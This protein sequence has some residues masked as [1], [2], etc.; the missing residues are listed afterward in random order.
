MIL[1][2]IKNKSENILKNVICRFPVTFILTI[3]W[4]IMTFLAWNEFIELQDSPWFINAL[5]AIVLAWFLSIWLYLIWESIDKKRS[6]TSLLQVITVVFGLVF[7]Y[8]WNLNFQSIESI[9]FI[10]I[11]SFWFFTLIFSAPFLVKIFKKEFEQNSF[12]KYFY[13]VSTIIFIT[14][15]L[16]LILLLLWMFIIFSVIYLFWIEKVVNEWDIIKNLFIFIWTLATPVFALLQLPKKESFSDTE[17]KEN[18]FFTFLIKYVSI[19]FAYIYFVILYLYSIT[20]IFSFPEWPKWEISWI[21]SL[22]WIFGYLIYIFSYKFEWESKPIKLFR[23]IF[24]IAMIPQALILLYSIYLRINQYDLTVN[25]YLVVIL[26]IWI[27]LISIYLSISKVKKLLII[28]SVLTILTLVISIWPW[29]IYNLPE[30]RQYDRLV[31]NLKEANI[32]VDWKIIPLESKDDISK[33]LYNEIYS[34][35][36]YLCDYNN[37]SSLEKLFPKEV[38]TTEKWTS[39]REILNKINIEYYYSSNDEPK[40]FSLSVKDN[41]ISPINIEWYKQIINFTWD[42]IYIWN[43]DYDK[44]ILTVWLEEEESNKYIINISDFVKNLNYTES[45]R[46]LSKEELT[47]ENDKYKIIFRNFNLQNPEYTKNSSNEYMYFPNLW[48]YLLVK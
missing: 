35:I 31:S 13:S 23:K 3:I 34:E 44:N 47:F 22:F 39:R 38:N 41:N 5:I 48:W 7:Y 12:Y 25:R 28:P 19:P 27:L 26:G 30:S 21:V 17:I 32:L 40:Y 42:E 37:C 16:G 14:Y 46:D 9:L 8:F 29:G 36:V 2:Y 20:L 15:L 24:P 45:N 18:S 43:F 10:A 4:S 11:T 1:E 33:D 6:V